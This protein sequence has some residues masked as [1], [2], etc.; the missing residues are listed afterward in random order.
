MNSRANPTTDAAYS[1]AGTFGYPRER[2][3]EQPAGETFGYPRH[4]PSVKRRA[5]ATENFLETI[6]EFAFM[7]MSLTFVDADRGIQWRAGL[8]HEFHAGNFR[9]I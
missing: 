8:R 5:P 1:C 9:S 7:A 4:A 6:C 2:L 3:F